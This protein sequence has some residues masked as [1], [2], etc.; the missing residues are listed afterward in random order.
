MSD[1][2]AT[3]GP[4]PLPQAEQPRQFKVKVELTG[5][6][7]GRTNAKMVPFHFPLPSTPVPQI[8]RMCVC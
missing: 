3:A 8:P 4:L 7:A 1:S 6:G 2:V 5:E